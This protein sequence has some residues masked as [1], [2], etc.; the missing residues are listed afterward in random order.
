MKLK[1]KEVN[2]NMATIVNTPTGGTDDSGNG[3]GFVFGMILLI[4]FL[5]LFIAYGVPVIRN[6]MGGTTNTNPGQINVNPPGNEGD[7]GAGGGI[8]VPEK[9]D[10]DVNQK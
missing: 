3:M 6:S 9:M 4:V 10:I 5:F 7:G 8:N 1:A 2:K